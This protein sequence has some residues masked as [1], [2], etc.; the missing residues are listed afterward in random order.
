MA[1]TARI[2]EFADATLR[3]V[4]R[5]GLAGVSYRSVAAE[6]GWSLGAVQKAFPTKRSLL[7]AALHR[8]RSLVPAQIGTAPGRPTLRSWLVELVLRTLPLDEQR[9]RVV[10]VGMAFAD[11]APYDTAIARSLADGDAELRASLQLL[12]RRAVHEGELDPA[13]DQERLARLILS[14]AAGLAGQLLY[15]EL[16]ENQVLALVEMGIQALLTPA[17]TQAPQ[18]GLPR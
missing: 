5:D 6:S 15:D 8:T 2:E 3:V 16:P 9:R 14:L 12:F 13:I 7:G 4:V 1:T 10:L 18:G 17:A 11:R